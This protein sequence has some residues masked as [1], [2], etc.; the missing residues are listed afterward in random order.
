M[1]LSSL[2]VLSERA[3]W[4]R[5]VVNEAGIVIGGNGGY[6]WPT[7]YRASP[8]SEISKEERRGIALGI[9]PVL[10]Y[11][12]KPIGEQFTPHHPYR[13]TKIIAENSRL[14]SK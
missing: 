4:G 14:Q 10:N 13:P 11:C 9:K 3:V 6:G 8:I 5:W 12:K 1:G 7:A 2:V